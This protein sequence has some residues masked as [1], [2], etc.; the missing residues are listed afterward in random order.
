MVLKAIEQAKPKDLYYVFM[1]FC[2]DA[3]LDNRL[4]AEWR[5]DGICYMQ[6]WDGNERQVQDFDDI[7]VG[8]LV[9]L[10]K[11]QVM[12]KTMRLYGHGRVA[13]IQYANHP[14]REDRYLTT[15][16]AAPTEEI[17]VPSIGCSARVNVRTADRVHAEMP[18]KFYEWLGEP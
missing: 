2:P 15:Q 1:G 4:D 11:N 13:G 12:G 5:R 3:T 10:K 18:D 8:D 9:V 16:W 7:K 6:H 14:L 17:E